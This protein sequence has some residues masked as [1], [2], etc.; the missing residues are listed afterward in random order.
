MLRTLLRDHRRRWGLA[1]LVIVASLIFVYSIRT[2][3][4]PFLVA[5]IVAY[6]L[7]PAVEYLHRQGLGRAWAI[8]VVY[9]LVGLLAGALV[10]FVL[11]VLIREFSGLAETIPE[12]T[13][14][15]QQVLTG[16]ERHYE[17]LALPPIIREALDENLNRLTQAAQAAI[18][19][20]VDA[21]IG[22]FAHTLTIIIVPVLA[23]YMLLDLPLFR[24]HME[25]LLPPLSRGESMAY[26]REIDRVLSGFIRGQLLVSGIVGS[27]TGVFLALI[28]VP[29]SFVLGLLAA[30]TNIIPYFGPFLGSA[31]GIIIA[32]SVSFPLAVKT[33]LVYAIIQQIEA[34]VLV[35]RIV[36][37]TVGLHPLGLVFALLVG[38]TYFGVGGLLLAVPAAGII[39]VTAGFILRRLGD[40]GPRKDGARATPPE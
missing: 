21:L 29:F 16:L 7:D 24:R 15:I 35:P 34:A 39:R 8:L 18:G 10:V 17:R 2:V 40:D 3:L 19:G 37:M 36:G 20:V 26:L 31:P 13:G 32:G 9:A 28:G 30:V 12:H 4:T 14:R 6:A 1:A 27:L 11:P 38:G 23:F 25:I 5:V 22:L 33:M